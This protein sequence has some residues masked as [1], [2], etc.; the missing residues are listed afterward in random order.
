MSLK[1]G[2]II[3]LGERQLRVAFVRPGP[4]SSGVC[5]GARGHLRSGFALPAADRRYPGRCL[6]LLPEQLIQRGSPDFRAGS[7]WHAHS[8]SNS[9]QT[10]WVAGC[11]PIVADNG[12]PRIA[13][14]EDCGY[15]IPVS[16]P[17]RMAEEIANIVVTIDRDRKIISEKGAKASKRIA[18]RYT[19]DNY[20][21]TVSAVYASVTKGGR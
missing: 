19:E 15:K 7:Q 1:T 21:R 12:G 2:K 20:R 5:S 6:A 16:T 9:V 10:V 17:N 8:G 14:T 11:V 4:D 13:V 3:R 18:T